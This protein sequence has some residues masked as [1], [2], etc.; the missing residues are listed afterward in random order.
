MGWRDRPF[1]ATSRSNKREGLIRSGCP[2]SSILRLAEAAACRRCRSYQ[3]IVPYI[4]GRLPDS[5]RRPNNKR[6]EGA[7]VRHD[8]QP[9]FLFGFAQPARLE[10]PDRQRSKT[11]RP[12]LVIGGLTLILI[13]PV[14]NP[15]L[16]TQLASYSWGHLSSTAV[17]TSP[18]REK[19]Y[20]TSWS[21]TRAR[22]PHQVAPSRSIYPT[23]SIS[24]YSS[25]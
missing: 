23:Q 24:R 19:Y 25:K 14:S 1:C 5:C 2:V 17:Q 22:L 12:G 8:A 10:P 3:Y 15:S 20:T 11:R 9:A 7:V 6:E 16:T 13:A 21:R 4:A 18:N